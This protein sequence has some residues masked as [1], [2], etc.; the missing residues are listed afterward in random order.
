MRDAASAEGG[1]AGQ[2]GH[3]GNVFRA[4]DPGA[5][6]GDVGEQ[7]ARYRGRDAADLVELLRVAADCEMVVSATAV[8]RSAAV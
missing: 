8:V 3:V 4:H 7:A 6:D 5:V 1:A 2:V